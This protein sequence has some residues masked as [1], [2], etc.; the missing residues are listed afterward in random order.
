MSK[1]PLSLVDWLLS[2]TFAGWCVED[3]LCCAWSESGASRELDF[4][5]ETELEK[6]YEGYLDTFEEE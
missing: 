1:Q 4:D 3:E 6:K 2:P 5:L